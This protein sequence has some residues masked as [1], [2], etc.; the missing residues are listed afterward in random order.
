MLR[1]KIIIERGPDWVKTHPDESP[2]VFK[3]EDPEFIISALATAMPS[4]R[5]GVVTHRGWKPNYS[6]E[7][8]VGIIDSNGNVQIATGIKQP[9]G[10]THTDWGSWNILTKH[11]GD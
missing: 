11:L 1:S 3:Y 10:S 6:F 7:V 8:P 9:D 2:L 5:S 4:Q